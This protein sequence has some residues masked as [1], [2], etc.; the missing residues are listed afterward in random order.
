LGGF[1]AFL[2]CGF[3][4]TCQG[5]NNSDNKQQTKFFHGGLGLNKK[6]RLFHSKESGKYFGLLR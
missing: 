6:S 4:A 5:K 1:I 2:V 3:L